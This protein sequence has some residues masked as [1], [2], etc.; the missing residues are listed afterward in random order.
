[1]ESTYVNG[2]LNGLFTK[3]D[4]T[5]KILI[6]GIY[7]DDKKEGVWKTIVSSGVYNQIT[8][9]Q[10]IMHGV[11]TIIQPDGIKKKEFMIRIKK[12]VLGIIGIRMVIKKL[13]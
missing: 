5:G 6:R 3:H 4:K 7:K 11:A 10:D 2:K 9:K 8:F 12:M 13:L 1:M